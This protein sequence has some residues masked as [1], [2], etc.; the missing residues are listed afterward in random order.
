[1]VFYTTEMVNYSRIFLKNAKGIK[2][3]QNNLTSYWQRQ[4]GLRRVQ[5]QTYILN[6]YD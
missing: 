5:D 6:F 1:M 3:Y 2:K 4:F